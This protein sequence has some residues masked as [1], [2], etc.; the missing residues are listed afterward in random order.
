MIEDTRAVTSLYHQFHQGGNLLDHLTASRTCPLIAPR[1]RRQ[2]QTRNRSV[3]NPTSVIPTGLSVRVVSSS[4]SGASKT[5]NINAPPTNASRCWS[6]HAPPHDRRC[7]PHATNTMSTTAASIVSGTGSA[8]SGKAQWM[9]KKAKVAP[10][11][12]NANRSGH[13]TRAERIAP[14]CAGSRRAIT[15]LWLCGYGPASQVLSNYMCLFCFL[16]W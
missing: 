7:T 14:R 10:K 12:I 2:S 16:P 6:V 15:N 3:V 9:T 1:T 4:C 11:P 8:N 5:K 13:G